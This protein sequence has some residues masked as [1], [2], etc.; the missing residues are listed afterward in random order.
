M[1]NYRGLENESFSQ[2]V[3]IQTTRLARD[4]VF[5]HFDSGR[6]PN[7]SYEDTQFFKLQTFMRMVRC[8]TV[9]EATHLQYRR[10]EEYGPHGDTHLRAL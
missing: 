8:G 6:A 1:T 7:A 9:Q 5:G 3:I 4:H 2:E 10:G